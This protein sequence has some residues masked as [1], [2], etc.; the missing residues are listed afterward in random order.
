MSREGVVYLAA[1][2]PDA[3]YKSSD[4]GVTYSLSL[5]LASVSNVYLRSIKAMGDSVVFLGTLTRNHTMYRSLDAGNTWQNISSKLP[6]SIYAICGL[7]VVGD[8]LVYGTGRYFGDAYLIKSSD[9]GE[10]WQYIDMRPWASNL[11]D[12]H[13]FTDKHG[14]VV[15][16]AP[17]ANQGATLL[18][19]TDGG[20]SWSTKWV[21]NV[22]GDRAWKFF[23]RDDAH[24]YVSIENTQSI[25]NRYFA[26][27]DSG[28]TWFVD[29]MGNMTMPMMQSVGFINADTGFAGGHFGGYL[30]TNDGGDNWQ[31]SNDFQGFNRMLLLGDR[32]FMSG[33]SFCYFGPLNSVS[34]E[35]VT[36]PNRKQHALQRVYPNPS[37]SGGYINVRFTAGKG[38]N[39]GFSL[40][41]IN[42]KVI[43][44]WPYMLA[45]EGTS[46]FEL[47]LPQVAKG[48][49]VL[50]AYTDS[51]HHQQKFLI[52]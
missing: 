23:K 34:V 11:I 18:E 49:Y 3:V 45:E 29:T 17:N 4:G 33:N 9:L 2:G 36:L 32:L 14:Y 16:R 46:E 24:F 13:F 5:N 26:S 7:S 39:I 20:N 35:P 43:Y 10:S 52:R 6:D 30:Y 50:V 42:G 15:G 41:D 1:N 40:S 12:V 44:D 28:H 27:A 19:T 38:T 22:A 47:R 21:S 31:M 25:P 8:S 51:E 37:E 48:M